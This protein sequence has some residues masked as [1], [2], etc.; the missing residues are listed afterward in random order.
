VDARRWRVSSG[1]EH[2][3]QP[4]I[5]RRRHESLDEQVRRL[6]LDTDVASLSFGVDCPLR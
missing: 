4:G 3:D 5:T 6:G 2:V 1:A